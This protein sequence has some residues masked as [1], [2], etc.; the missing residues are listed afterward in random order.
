MAAV[1]DEIHR[2]GEGLFDA[3]AERLARPD[4]G[5]RERLALD[6]GV[7][8]QERGVAAAFSCA[9]FALYI[10]LSRLLSCRSDSISD[11]VSRLPGREGAGFGLGEGV[12]AAAGGAAEVGF[13]VTESVTDLA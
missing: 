2:A 1:A 7:L 12:E 9:I 3:G 13:E 10:A 6:V 11:G 8:A 4:A 5:A